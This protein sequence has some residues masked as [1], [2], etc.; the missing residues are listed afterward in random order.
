MTAA[1]CTAL[2]VS[3]APQRAS[4]AP[5]D[6]SA[7]APALPDVEGPSRGL[8]T[9]PA[10][11]PLPVENEQEI[12]GEP[13]PAPSP[14]A[15]E[16]AASVEPPPPSLQQP[17]RVRVAVGLSAELDGSKSELELLDSLELGV[18][19]SAAPAADVRRLRVGAAEPRTLCREGRDDLIINVGYMP[20]RS[21]PVL[22][23]HDCRIDEALGIRA[24][25]AAGDPLL[26]GV[27]WTEHRQRVNEGARERRRARLSPK[28]RTG[29]IA[30]VA[31][32]VVGAAI[33]LLIAG[34]VQKETVVLVISPNP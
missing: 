27:L 33:S 6:A 12:T 23:T 25:E 21:D 24:A 7:D 11:D 29:I 16:P 18:R 17:E 3:A 26:L 15:S 34:A 13:A 32:V 31:V 30:G 10:P 4:A 22:L 8:D 9:L 1:L 28:A 19:Q 14:A 5:P 20:D 2:L